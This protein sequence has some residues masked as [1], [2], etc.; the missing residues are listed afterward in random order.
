MLYDSNDLEQNNINIETSTPPDTK[1][2]YVVR[3]HIHIEIKYVDDTDNGMC[4]CS[5]GL[6]DQ[7]NGEPCHHQAGVARKYKINGLNVIPTFNADGC[8]LFAQIAVGKAV[9][10]QSFYSGL[11]NGKPDINKGIHN[12]TSNCD[13]QSEFDKPPQTDY[14]EG[15]EN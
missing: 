12:S 2:L 10:P 7:P 5:L 11:H 8:F 14:D 6:N 1:G 9:S 15:A 3:S 13:G 4:T